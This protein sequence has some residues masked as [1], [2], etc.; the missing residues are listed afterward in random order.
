MSLR[1]QLSRE[2]CGCIWDRTTST[3]WSDCP[4]HARWIHRAIARVNIERIINSR[5]IASAA[6]PENAT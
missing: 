5:A 6:Q 2:A 4:A 1:D 3:W